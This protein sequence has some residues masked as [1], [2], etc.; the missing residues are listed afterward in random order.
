MG[1]KRVFG[2]GI[3]AGFLIAMLA[4]SAGIPAIS[5][6]A[7]SFLALV[8]TSILTIIFVSPSFG[9][10][11]REIKDLHG[12]FTSASLSCGVAGVAVAVT[13]K[14]SSALSVP[15]FWAAG[16]TG[17]MVLGYCFFGFLFYM[18]VKGTSRPNN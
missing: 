1:D 16:L 17:A 12:V 6:T 11:W 9:C 13:I 15:L 10:N 3:V 14:L 4:I 18:L 7:T 5:V 2:A 8:I